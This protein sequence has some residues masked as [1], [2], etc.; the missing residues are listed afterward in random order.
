VKVVRTGLFIHKLFQQAH[1]EI[2]HVARYT[3]TVGLINVFLIDY[4]F[5]PACE[6]RAV[7]EDNP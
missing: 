2:R 5:R 7:F 3:G 1:P 6:S 4:L